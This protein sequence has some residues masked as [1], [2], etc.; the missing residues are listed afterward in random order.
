[1]SRIHLQ[2]VHESEIAP[3]Q[4]DLQA[5]AQDGPHG[6]DCQWLGD[7]A[8]YRTLPHRWVPGS[9]SSYGAWQGDCS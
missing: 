9:D 7:G 8:A 3:G 1:M 5:P 2:V 6:S 4:Y